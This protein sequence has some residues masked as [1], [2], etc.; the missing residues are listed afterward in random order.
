MLSPFG[1]YE[2]SIETPDGARS[3]TVSMSVPP[4]AFPNFFENC[5][6]SVFNGAGSLVHEETRRK[7]IARNNND[8]MQ[9]GLCHEDN[10]S[11]I[12]INKGHEEHRHI[13]YAI[14]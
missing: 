14:L 13:A 12:K 5:K 3:A 11:Q 4:N 10:K 1:I 2:F 8:F 9:A 6:E 7:I